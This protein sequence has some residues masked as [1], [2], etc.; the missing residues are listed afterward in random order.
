MLTCP[1]YCGWG[2]VAGGATRLRSMWGKWTESNEILIFKKYFFKWAE[3]LCFVL[4]LTWDEVCASGVTTIF[5][6][7]NTTDIYNNRSNER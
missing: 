4:S 1:W 6:E 7:H 3:R 5:N 2:G